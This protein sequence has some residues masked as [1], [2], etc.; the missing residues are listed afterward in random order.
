MPLTSLEIIAALFALIGLIKIIVILI[1]KKSWFSVTKSVY[2]NP[3]A[4]SLIF[5]ILALIVFYFLIQEL[6][7]IEIIAAAAF[8][9]LLMGLAFLQ[10]S[11][12]I[13]TLGNKMLNKKFTGWQLFIM[14]VWLILLIW[15]IYSI[16]FV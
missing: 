12:D 9:S 1:N 2:G 13:L 15:T 7:I 11:K 10:V 16:F 4:S 6:T 3:A 5:F 8:I 14:I